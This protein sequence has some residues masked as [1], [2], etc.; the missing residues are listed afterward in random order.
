MEMIFSRNDKPTKLT[1]LQ[2]ATY[3]LEKLSEGKMPPQIIEEM[4]DDIQLVEIWMDF[5]VDMRWIERNTAAA[6]AIQGYIVT[7]K[8]KEWLAK[9]SAF[10][11][12]SPTP[13]LLSNTNF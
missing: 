7:A 2:Q 8:G 1:A 9:L 11:E 4:D 3:V 10:A 5:L 13:S 12:P 6:G